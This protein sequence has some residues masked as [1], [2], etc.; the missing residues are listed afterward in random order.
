MCVRS[1]ACCITESLVQCSEACTTTP[2]G[3]LEQQLAHCLA[4]TLCA[5][6]DRSY[7]SEGVCLLAHTCC[8]NTAGLITRQ[9]TCSSHLLAL[10]CCCNLFII[11]GAPGDSIKLQSATCAPAAGIVKP[12]AAKPAAAGRKML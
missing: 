5:G 12:A 8:K 4:S 2:A 6:P 10:C 9:L 11:T 7:S 3:R 1:L